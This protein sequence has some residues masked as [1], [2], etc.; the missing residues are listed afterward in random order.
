MT[1]LL[2]AKSNVRGWYEYI[3]KTTD[4]I[5]ADDGKISDQAREAIAKDILEVRVRDG[6]RAPRDV[7]DGPCEFEILLSNG[8]PA[9]R[10]YG[11][12]DSDGEPVDAE[13]QAQDWGTHW[14]TVWETDDAILLAYARCFRFGG[15]HDK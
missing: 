13:L 12:L 10:V 2:H 11:H 4:L 8:S 7:S 9:I 14:T 6:W 3:C 5:A 15:R 1:A